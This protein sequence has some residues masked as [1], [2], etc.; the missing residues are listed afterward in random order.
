[1]RL[2]GGALSSP[3]VAIVI[4]TNSGLSY[5]VNKIIIISTLFV[6]GREVGKV[7][8]RVTSS[9]TQDASFTFNNPDNEIAL[10]PN[11]TIK[12]G[13]ADLE[14]IGIGSP[15]EM[16]VLIYDDDGM[17]IC[18]SRESC[19]SI[20]YFIPLVV[21]SVTFTSPSYHYSEDH[22][23]VDNIGLSISHQIAQDLEIYYS[24]GNKTYCCMSEV[25]S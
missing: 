25:A 16:T 5:I 13:I 3:V 4:D 21:V 7:E 6:I 15:S 19:G 9:T 12:L 23:R 10:E 24:G 11:R 17:I 20:M 8:F 18:Y 1:M 2:Q 14:E 22:G